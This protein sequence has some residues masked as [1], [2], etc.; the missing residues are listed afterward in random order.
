MMKARKLLLV[1]VVAV[2]CAGMLGVAARGAQKHL[3]MPPKVMDSKTIFIDNRSGNAAV[4]DYAYQELA[5]WGRY[6]ILPA[7]DEAELVLKF[8]RVTGMRVRMDLI[9]PL[10]GGSLWESSKQ[11]RSRQPPVA[12][13]F[14]RPSAARGL[15]K[16]FRK[17]VEEQAHE[18][19]AA[20]RQLRDQKQEERR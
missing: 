13:I 19:G 5:K 11:T 14:T 16:E 18:P 20:D 3:P 15:V 12:Q 6:K 2:L 9:D 17:R 1:P 8:T 10:T 7:I 4:G